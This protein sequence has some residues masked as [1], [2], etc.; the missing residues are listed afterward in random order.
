MMVAS[1]HPCLDHERRLPRRCPVRSS[2]PHLVAS[3]KRPGASAAR[4]VSSATAFRSYRT[5]RW[6]HGDR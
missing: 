5:C 1:H 2:P 3:A 6:T 4:S